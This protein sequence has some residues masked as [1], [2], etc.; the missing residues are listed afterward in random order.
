MSAIDG[1][2]QIIGEVLMFGKNVTLGYHRDPE[3]SAA[4]FSDGWFHSRDLAVMHQG[5]Y[6]EP[7]IQKFLLRQRV[8]HRPSVLL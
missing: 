8:E 1:N 3:T 5:G 4:A 2:G 6:V 7:R